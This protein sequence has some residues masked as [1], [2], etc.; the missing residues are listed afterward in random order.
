MFKNS[1]R[2]AFIMNRAIK[3]LDI[4]DKVKIL[5][6]E[7]KLAV[8]CAN[9][10]PAKLAGN[11]GFEGLFDFSRKVR[12]RCGLDIVEL[13]DDCWELGQLTHPEEIIKDGSLFRKIEDLAAD[14]DVRYI[15]AGTGALLSY[16]H[17]KSMEQGFFDV[18]PNARKYQ[19]GL[20][21]AWTD[22]A[23]ELGVQLYT[24]K[25]VAKTTPDNSL[26]MLGEFP[27]LLRQRYGLDLRPVNL[28][29]LKKHQMITASE[30]MNIGLA[31]R[32]NQHN[33]SVMVLW[34]QMQYVGMEPVTV[35]QVVRLNQILTRNV[36][37]GHYADMADHGH[38]SDKGTKGKDIGPENYDLT[39]FANAYQ[40]P[41]VFGHH[42]GLFDNCKQ[43]YTAAVK[44]RDMAAKDAADI[45]GKNI[46]NS[47]P[48]PG[49]FRD[50]NT[51]WLLPTLANTN[52]RMVIVS[53]EPKCGIGTN[54]DDLAG[55]V[56]EATMITA[57]CL[58]AAGYV[59][60]AINPNFFITQGYKGK[61]DTI[62][63][64]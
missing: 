21:D 2:I 47:S 29:D 31:L 8:L 38:V 9:N 36:A 34:E 19:L 4:Y 17:M 14:A 27:E 20:F 57:G 46:T 63:D 42:N 3:A 55:K 51:G 5:D 22:F 52:V 12:E 60:S 30:A 62:L 41:I 33:P 25:R 37:R 64:K 23:A 24:G 6:N 40:G 53:P 50:I 11:V 10:Y 58:E 44:D 56:A 32:L 45:E 16:A 15:A 7:A 59:R 54:I 35:E 28:Q 49:L 1:L 43:A 26:V 39:N 13:S 18:S 48:Y 61:L